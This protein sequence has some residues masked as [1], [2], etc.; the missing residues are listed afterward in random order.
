MKTLSPNSVFRMNLLL[1]S[2]RV[3]KKISPPEYVPFLYPPSTGLM[4]I[5]IGIGEDSSPIFLPDGNKLGFLRKL[6][7]KLFFCIVGTDGRFIKSIPME[8][9]EIKSISWKDSADKI[10]FA[11]EEDI[12]ILDIET[13]KVTKLTDTGNNNSPVFNSGCIFFLKKEDSKYHVYRISGGGKEELIIKSIVQMTDAAISSCGNFFAWRLRYDMFVQDIRDF[14][15]GKVPETADWESYKYIYAP[16][17]FT[18]DNAKKIM[19]NIRNSP[20]MG[21]HIPSIIRIVGRQGGAVSLP[22]NK[23]ENTA[24]FAWSPLNDSFALEKFH[25]GEKK[26][27]LQKFMASGKQEIKGFLPE[28]GFYRYKLQ[29]GRGYHPEKWQ[30]ITGW[31]YVLPEDEL[32]GIWDT[33]RCRDGVY[34]VML[35]AETKAGSYENDVMRVLLRK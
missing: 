13:E 9:A 3:R 21:I 16:M 32:L 17:S 4:Q 27:F 12:W 26:I 30:D 34:S 23:I 7:N 24:C 20:T 14:S 6:N 5:T 22:V 8:F 25:E 15:A 31:I 1:L 19:L 29:A 35:I 18:H 11:S 10:V 33:R 2:E 28:K